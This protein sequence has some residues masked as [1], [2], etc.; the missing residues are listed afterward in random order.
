M[1]ASRP[2]RAQGLKTR[3][4]AVEA[5]LN[6][7]AALQLPAR[8]L[9]ANPADLGASTVVRPEEGCV[10]LVVG[11]SSAHA[12]ELQG[13]LRQLSAFGI[14]GELQ[15]HSTEAL[16]RLEEGG[17]DVVVAFDD[18]V[19]R[20]VQRTIVE[21]ELLVPLVTVRELP[22]ADA[23]GERLRQRE[24]G[25]AESLAFDELS[26]TA[27]RVALLGCVESHRAI[28]RLQTSDTASVLDPDTGLF[29]T[30]ALRRRIAAA[31]ERSD[32]DPGFRYSLLYIDTREIRESY[33]LEASDVAALRTRVGRRLAHVANDYVAAAV[34]A[35]GY[36]VLFR[37]FDEGED[38]TSGEA[39]R[40]EIQRPYELEDD[41]L[42]LD[43]GFGFAR[44]RGLDANVD[45]AIARAKSQTIVPRTPRVELYDD[46][47]AKA[48]TMEVLAS[49]LA[50]ALRHEEFSITYQPIVDIGTQAPMGFEA[51]IRWRHPDGQER[52]ASEFINAA[53][54]TN[55]IVPI[56]YWCVEE[57]MRQMA[58]W[59]QELDG[60]EDLA[61]SLNLSAPQVLDPLFVERVRSLLMTTGLDAS[62]V[63]FEIEAGTI[64]EHNEEARALVSGLVASGT[65]VWV[66]DYGLSECTIDDLRGFPLDGFKI[67]RR[68]V[69]RIDGTEMTSGRIRHIVTAA[70]ALGL[71]TLGEGIEN[72]LQANVLRWLGCSLGQGYLYSRPMSVAEVYGYLA[73]RQ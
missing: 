53:N 49:D 40:K 52:P 35:T 72:P 26:P 45:A 12:T 73:G 42:H 30:L 14:R 23:A 48:P 22:I 69:S 57:A 24:F 7:S 36:V 2:D 21:R 50:H 41:R 4:L 46:E 56:G 62:S 10:A 55:L 8:T 27:L 16:A 6:V 70:K 58:D 33:H 67:D 15:P 64:S 1:A 60:A 29:T 59:Q 51:L 66:E 28:S 54:D 31:I 65:K 9:T 43:L 19:G 11:G 61:I 13:M 18:Y 39:V 37:G 25:A 47:R 34:D 44:G 32:F 63:R 3:C 38:L 20:S 5:S 68:F 17:V 71:R